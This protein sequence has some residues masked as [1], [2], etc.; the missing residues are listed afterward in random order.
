MNYTWKYMETVNHIRTMTG[1]RPSNYRY[2]WKPEEV[3]AFHLSNLKASREK[4]SREKAMEKERTETAE[5]ARKATK[6]K[7]AYELCQEHRLEKVTRTSESTDLFIKCCFAF[8]F[9]AVK[10]IMTGPKNDLD[11]TDERT[12]KGA[13]PM[14]IR[15]VNQANASYRR[16]TGKDGLDVLD[17]NTE[18]TMT[19]DYKRHRIG[20]ITVEDEEL[21]NELTEE[22]RE[23]AAIIDKSREAIMALA[24]DFDDLVG[25]AILAMWEEWDKGSVY[26]FSDLWKMRFSAYRAVNTYVTRQKRRQANKPTV[27]LADVSLYV[28]D[29]DADNIYENVLDKQTVIDLANY[30]ETVYKKDGEIARWSFVSGMRGMDVRTAAGRYGCHYSTIARWRAKVAGMLAEMRDAI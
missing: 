4:A 14:I 6:R 24:N 2:A 8:T 30:V 5:K 13:S 9:T 28:R 12:P 27:S 3:E 23:R 22:G 1:G 25:I 17:A 11:N 21:T 10:T 18:T 16:M 26:T 29:M 19:A 15:L 7:T 20:G